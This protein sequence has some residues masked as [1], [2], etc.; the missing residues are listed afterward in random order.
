MAEEF[1]NHLKDRHAAGGDPSRPFELNIREDFITFRNSEVQ[2]S[3]RGW[4][5]IIVGELEEPDEKVP[6]E[7]PMIKALDRSFYDYI[8]DEPGPEEPLQ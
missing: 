3:L 2:H 6:N 4:D 8:D 7:Y 1:F 5:P